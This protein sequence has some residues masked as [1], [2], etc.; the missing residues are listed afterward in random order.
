P[1][2]HFFLAR[3]I[4][5]F[6]GGVASDDYRYGGVFFGTE[7]HTGV[8]IKADP[9]TPVLAA[10]DGRVV[11][12][13]P[14]LY[15]GNPA[16]T[17]DPYGIAVLIRHNFGWEGEAVHTLYAHLS[18]VLVQQGDW[19]TVGT[20]IGLV[21]TT[22]H[23][24]GPHL[25]FEVRIGT[26]DRTSPYSGARN[27]DLWLVPPIGW[28]VLVGQVRS[29]GGQWLHHYKVYL[30]WDDGHLRK[31]WRTYTYGQGLLSPDPYYRE[32][33]TVGDLPAGRY[34][35]EITYNYRTYAQ[36]VEI[37]PGQIT[38]FTFRGSAGFTVGLPPLP[39]ADWQP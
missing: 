30:V 4:A 10:G 20:P 17:D 7:V 27:P 39:E 35:I 18:K 23:S 8:D 3:P 2:D 21:G 33:Y 22:G 14:G 9:G 38:Y 1:F 36:E 6:Y 25:H 15:Y 19:V 28:G 24:T 13:G 31:V 12:A 16:R 5:A 32:N 37:A 29:T 34:T 11:W 26:I